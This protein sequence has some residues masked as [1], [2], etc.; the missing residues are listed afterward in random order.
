MVFFANPRD[1]L[2]TKE[3]LGQS[4]LLWP[5]KNLFSHLKVNIH[6]KQYVIFK[7]HNSNFGTITNEQM[8][9]QGH[10]HIKRALIKLACTFD[11]FSGPRFKHLS[12]DRRQ[13]IVAMIEN[14]TSIIVGGNNPITVN[15]KFI[16]F[17]YSEK[18]TKFCEIFTLVCPM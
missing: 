12:K 4:F 7:I 5:I 16:K 6:N 1:Q 9:Y 10:K 17:I 11:I 13:D 3:K 2:K 15:W 14:A 18:A 8:S